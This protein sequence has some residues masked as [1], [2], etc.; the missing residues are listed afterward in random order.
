MKTC[1]TRS[2]TETKPQFNIEFKKKIQFLIGEEHIQ[3]P[4]LLHMFQ[5]TTL[6]NRQKYI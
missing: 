4:H 2:F 3:R 1:L 5:L 6:S